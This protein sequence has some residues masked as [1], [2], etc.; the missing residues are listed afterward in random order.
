M[1]SFLRTYTK[2]VNHRSPAVRRTTRHGFVQAT[3]RFN[4]TMPC[5]QPNTKCAPGVPP[6]IVLCSSYFA[7]SHLV[8]DSIILALFHP[9]AVALSTGTPTSGSTAW[10]AL[11]VRAIHTTLQVTVTLPGDL[12]HGTVLWTV[13]PNS[14]SRAQPCRPSEMQYVTSVV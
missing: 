10:I 1:V 9:T 3:W 6:P 7:D 8:L 5:V 12:L 11:F 4:L 13:G 14:T 2:Q